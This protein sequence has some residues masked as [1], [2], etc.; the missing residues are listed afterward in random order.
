[1]GVCIYIMEA[2]GHFAHVNTAALHATKVFP[3][4]KIELGTFVKN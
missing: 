4:T 3:E 2:N 1:M